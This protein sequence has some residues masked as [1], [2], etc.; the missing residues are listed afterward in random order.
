MTCNDARLA[1]L[2]L[3]VHPPSSH[4][5]FRHSSDAKFGSVLENATKETAG[6]GMHAQ[7]FNLR[8]DHVNCY[9]QRS[10][11]HGHDVDMPRLIQM[12]DMNVS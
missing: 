1:R 11:M 9:A 10:V 5:W 4:N 8:Q 3:L 7:D 6:K 12:C 2:N